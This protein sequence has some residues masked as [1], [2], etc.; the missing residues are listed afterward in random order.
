MD[1]STEIETAPPSAPQPAWDDMQA[2]LRLIADQKAADRRLAQLR[3]ATTAMERQRADLA[4]ARQAHDETVSKE[5]AQLERDLTKLREREVK[6]AEREGLLAHGSELLRQQ[7]AALDIRLGREE[8]LPG[9]MTRSWSEDAA[10]RPPEPDAHYRQAPDQD[11]QVPA[12]VTLTR[13][14]PRATNI[15]KFRRSNEEQTS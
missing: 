5:R 2:L 12:S 10:D 8:V 6:L 9:G 4:T 13:S 3:A 15:T 1:D 14:S 11:F 7:K